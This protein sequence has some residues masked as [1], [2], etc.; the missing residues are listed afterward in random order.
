MSSSFSKN[1]LLTINYDGSKLFGWQDNQT[2]RTVENALQNALTK[3][4][5]YSVDL[6]AVSRTDAGVHAMDQKINFFLEKPFPIEKLPLAINSHLPKDIRITDAIEKPLSFHPTLDCISKE[7][8]YFLCMKTHQ[9]P[10]FRKYSWHVHHTLNFESMR[11]ASKYFIGRH[12]FSAFCTL[13]K[14]RE[15]KD[16]NCTIESIQ[17]DKLEGER[18]KISICG[19]R[20]LYRMARALV[21]NL[22]AVGKGDLLP[23]DMKTILESKKREKAMQTAPPHGL[24]LAKVNYLQNEAK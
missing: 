13:L 15:Y 2:S 4:L 12:D 23:F 16:H 18:L 14:Y 22:I 21:G 11:E 8:W 6:Q 19:D 1:I 7:Y 20:F 9:I 5:G 17:I 3:I 24:F 10:F